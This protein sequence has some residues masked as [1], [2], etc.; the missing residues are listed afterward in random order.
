MGIL[1][2]TQWPGR[3]LPT[4]VVENVTGEMKV[5]MMRSIGKVSLCWLC[6]L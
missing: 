5:G 6:C 3:A 1:H 2:Q 4:P